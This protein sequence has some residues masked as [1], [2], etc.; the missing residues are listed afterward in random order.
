[1]IQQTTDKTQSSSTQKLKVDQQQNIQTCMDSMSTKL[2]SVT[3]RGLPPSRVHLKIMCHS[4][5]GY[6][7]SV[8]GCGSKRRHVVVTQRKLI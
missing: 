5:T 6:N 7:Q 4:F 1:M 3:G 2:K 8:T